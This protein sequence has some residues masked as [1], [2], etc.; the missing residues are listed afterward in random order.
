MSNLNILK[1][2]ASQIGI[3]EAAGTKDNPQVVEYHAYSTKSN[4]KGWADSVPWCAS[5]ICWVVEKCGFE[6]TNSAR[7]R[8]YEKWGVDV[9]KS[10]LPGDVVVFWR[11][12]LASGKGHVTILVKKVGNFLYCVGGNQSDS[13]NLTAYPMTKLRSIRRAPGVVIGATEK[14]ELMAFADKIMAGKTV[15]KAGKVV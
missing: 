6:S 12:T 1:K 2:A 5:F 8:S 11:D 4:K 7:A 10:P 15:N 3:K 14:A 13:V 9:T